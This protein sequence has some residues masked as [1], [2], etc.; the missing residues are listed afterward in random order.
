M[1]CTG[2]RPRTS[3]SRNTFPEDSR[4]C[5]PPLRCTGSAGSPLSADAAARVKPNR[6]NTTAARTPMQTAATVAMANSRRAGLRYRPPR[7]SPRTTD[8]RSLSKSLAACAARR[9][10]SGGLVDVTIVGAGPAGL[11]AAVYGASKGLTTVVLDAVGPGG[12]AAA[13]SRIENYLGFPS[14]ISGAERA[15]TQAL[16]F[17]ARLSTPCEIVA[18]AVDEHLRA[19]LA[20]DTDI[21]TRAL[22]IAPGA[23]YG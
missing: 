5:L 15:E 18:L 22:I 7:A 3:T 1:R 20:D 19:V 21:P 11:A 2:T 17:G 9:D 23:R 13:S 16:K 4:P 6:T 12:Q 10:D 14:G 8:A